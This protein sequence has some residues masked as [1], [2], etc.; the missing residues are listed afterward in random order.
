[1]RS[2]VDVRTVQK[3]LGHFDLTTTQKY[4][5]YLVAHSDEAGV[6][7]NKTFAVFAPAPALTPAER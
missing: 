6:A 7:V 2:G 5:D 1:L 4:C 3:W